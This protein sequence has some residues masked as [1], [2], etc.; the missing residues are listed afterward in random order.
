M[1]AK[2]LKEL[3]TKIS[4]AKHTGESTSALEFIKSIAKA[5]ANKGNFKI[6][7]NIETIHFPRK[8]IIAACKLLEKEGFKF[9]IFTEVTAYYSNT[10]FDQAEFLELSWE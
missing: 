3:A 8:A 4:E 10:D 1:L 6:V 2:E 9:R 7:R 5:A